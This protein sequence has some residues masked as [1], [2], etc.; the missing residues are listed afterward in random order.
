[1]SG[2]GLGLIM[3]SLGPIIDKNLT[4]EKIKE[5][6]DN[7]TKEYPVLDGEVRNIG[8]VSLESDGKTYFSIVGLNQQNKI[9]CVKKQWR[10]VEGIKLL[11]SNLPK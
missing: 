4:D 2:F 6:F 8:I 11:L 5:V 3:N 7:M 9:V 10:L 1:M